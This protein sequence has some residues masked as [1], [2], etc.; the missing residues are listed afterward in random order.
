M[1]YIQN[2]IN[3]LKTRKNRTKYNYHSNMPELTGEQK[4]MS[5]TDYLFRRKKE[6]NDSPERKLQKKICDYLQTYYPDVYFFSD[7]SGLKLSPNILKL[8]KATRSRHSQLDIVI[9]H[10]MVIVLE[11]KSKSPYQKSGELFNDTHLKEQSEVMQMLA[12]NGCFCGFVWTLD[13]C[14]NIFTN[15][16]GEPLIDNTPLFA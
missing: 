8:L 14:I 10:K 5:D 16:L 12:N 7:P 6:R 11:V 1:W 9:L 3:G 15:H 13:Q 2:Y 4:A